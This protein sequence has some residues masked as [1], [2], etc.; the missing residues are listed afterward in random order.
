MPA[1]AENDPDVSAQQSLARF[2]ALRLASLLVNA[3]IAGIFGTMAMIVLVLWL[4]KKSGLALETA[5]FRQ[6]MLMVFFII[7]LSAYVVLEFFQHRKDEHAAKIAAKTKRKKP[8]R[9]AAFE[10]I[11]VEPEP[12]P[13][14]KPEEVPAAPIT[15]DP[16]TGEAKVAFGGSAP[17]AGMEQAPPLNDASATLFVQAVNAAVAGL[18]DDATVFTTFGLHL[19]VMG[20]CGE[21][22]RRNGLAPAPGKALFVRMLHDAGMAKRGAAAF[23]VNANTFAQV[24]NF[25]GPID[26]GYRAMAHLQDAGFV[27]VADL[28]DMITQWGLQESICRAP[29][30]MTFVATSV[31]FAG[32]AVPA[33][34]RLR[35][36]RA[37]NKAV[38]EMLAQFQGRE[39]SNLGHGIVAAFT[40][41]AAAVRAAEA[42]Q[43]YLDLFARENPKLIVAPRVGIDTEMAAVV[44]GVY[45]SAAT[46]RAVTIAALAPSHCIYCSEAT[47]EEAAEVVA[48]E[49]APAEGAY[50]DLPPLFEA[51]WSRAPAKEGPALEYR[52]IGTLVDINPALAPSP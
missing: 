22:V 51:R 12:A 4:Q 30:M 7:M 27:N 1:V 24:P 21:L 39:I 33:E 48:F 5:Q 42:F 20:G 8:R 34:D 45:V 29:D 23:A 15:I 13:A 17:A 35:V 36:L 50:G 10:A 31:S 38:T 2:R 40:D 18:A 19:F 41:A 9:D 3:L 47:A 28:L 49:P 25:R 37:H 32:P 6:L 52:Q 26:A 43:E 46:A 16:A 14:P 44:D 11:F